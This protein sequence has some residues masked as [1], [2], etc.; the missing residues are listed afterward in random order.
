MSPVAS[1][2]R[3]RSAQSAKTWRRKRFARTGEITD[4]CPVPLSLTVTTPSSR[5]PALSHF[6]IRRMMRGSATRCSRK[7]TSHSWLTASNE[8]VGRYPFPEPGGGGFSR[9]RGHRSRTPALWPAVPGGV[10]ERVARERRSRPRPRRPPGARA[11][12]AAARG[13]EPRPAAARRRD[14]QALRRSDA[15]ADRPGRG[16]RGG[17]MLVRPERVWRRTPEALR[18]EIAG[19]VAALLAEVI[20]EIGTDRRP[21]PRPARGD[22]HPPVHAAPGADQPGEPAPAV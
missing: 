5:T 22:L 9:G 18:R 2:R 14:E 7:R 20:H 1:R 16:Q 6:R 10:G 21:P 12:E 13:D 19:D 3:Q 8:D 11:A 4:P 15:G 17:G